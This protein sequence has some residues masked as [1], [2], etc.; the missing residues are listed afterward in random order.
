VLIEEEQPDR[1]SWRIGMALRRCG[2]TQ[3]VPAPAGMRWRP[4][5]GRLFAA[6]AVL[7]YGW[8]GVVI[9]DRHIIRLLRVADRRRFDIRADGASGLTLTAGRLCYST[10][11]DALRTARLPVH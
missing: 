7:G 8:V 3:A 11:E 4:G 10:G 2:S 6:N 9:G 5:S 1:T